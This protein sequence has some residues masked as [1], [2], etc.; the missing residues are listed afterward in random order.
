[1]KDSDFKCC[2]KVNKG[3][4]EVYVNFG[5][6]FF[7]T[8][9]TNLVVRNNTEVDTVRGENL[10][11]SEIENYFHQILLSFGTILYLTMLKTFFFC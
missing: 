5:S 2:T 7:K 10:N 9:L 1:M 4:P 11:S 6:L 3:G 8:I